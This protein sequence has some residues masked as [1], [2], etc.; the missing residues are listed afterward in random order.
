M[1]HGDADSKVLTAS[2]PFLGSIPTL[3]W[4]LM[5]TGSRRPENLFRSPDSGLLIYRSIGDDLPPLTREGQ[6]YDAV[7]YILEVCSGSVY[8]YLLRKRLGPIM[9]K[10]STSLCMV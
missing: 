6:M 3:S 5:C 7:K 8:I 9:L 1:P 10:Y 4:L 2:I